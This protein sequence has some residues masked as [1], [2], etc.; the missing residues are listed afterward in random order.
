MSFPPLITIR[1][2]NIGFSKKKNALENKIIMIYLLGV[3]HD[4]L[5]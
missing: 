1:Y 4:Q 2:L 3:Y 5:Y